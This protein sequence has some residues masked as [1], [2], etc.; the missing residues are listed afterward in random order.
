MS[1]SS[2]RCACPSKYGASRSRV[3]LCAR[4]RKRPGGSAGPLE[5]PGV[6]L[7]GFAVVEPEGADARCPVEAAGSDVILL[8]EPKGAIVLGVDGHAA[9][10]APAFVGVELHAD[11]KD[12][13]TFW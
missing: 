5:L 1:P 6:L 7:T 13:C 11:P 4:E 9:V 8:R 3:L 12:D 2:R 10:I